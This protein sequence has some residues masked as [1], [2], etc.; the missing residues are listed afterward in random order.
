MFPACKQCNDVSRD[1]EKAL[2]ILLH[3]ERGSD[4]RTKYL[5]NLKSLAGEHRTD[6]NGMVFSSSN[7][8]RRAMRSCGIEIPE[9]QS[10]YEFPLVKLPVEFWKDRI[11]MVGRK[12]FLA[13]HYQCF[14]KPIPKGGGL[15]VTFM[16]NAD[17]QANGFLDE[18][19]REATNFVIPKRNGKPLG[20]QFAIRYNCVEGHESALFVIKMHDVLVYQGVTTN[21]LQ[22]FSDQVQDEFL[23]PFDWD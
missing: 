15:Q 19:M 23:E 6:I 13:L 21:D 1:A 5:A 16:T 3:G 7:E 8:K 22:L 17:V 12:L 4:D 14:G 18:V 2:G 9:G 20:D 10:F 11:E